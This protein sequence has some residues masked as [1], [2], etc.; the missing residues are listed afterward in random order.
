M[1]AIALGT[2]VKRV[3]VLCGN[4]AAAITAANVYAERLREHDVRFLEEK[5]LSIGR[6]AA[7][8]RR[9]LRAKGPVSLA[10]SLAYYGLR[11]FRPAEKPERRYRPALVTDNFNADPAIREYIRDFMPD[12]VLVACCGILGPDMLALLPEKTFNIH[13]GISPRYRGFGNI[14]A[15]RD[16]RPD[17][18]GYTV[19]KVDAGIDTGERITV[20]RLTPRDIAGV[21]FT[22][23]DVPVYALAADH[24]ADLLLD[25]AEAAI[26][27]EFRE[28]PSEFHGVPTLSVYLT[29]RKNF[30]ATLLNIPRH[31]LITGASSGIGSALA[32]CCAAPGVRLSLWARDERRLAGV[33]A[34][35]RARGAEVVV[36]SQDIRDH[37]RTRELLKQIDR[38]RPVDL[39]VL[40]AGVSS[41]TLPGGAPEPVEAA[42][43]TMDVN[44]TAAVNMAGTL[45]ALMQPR[46]AGHVA[47]ISS[48]AALH[49]LPD[50]PAY[51][52]SKAALAYYARAVRPLLYPLRVS[53]IYPGYVD[54]PMSARIAGPQP[55]RW[56]VERAAAHIRARLDAGAE[57]IVFPRLL[58]L[59]VLL[60]NALPARLAN[61]FLKWFAFR[62][63]PGKEHDPAPA[64]PENRH[65]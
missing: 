40:G 6:I 61:F 28:M 43:R 53:V 56:T 13:P 60:L 4:D 22:G 48:I 23:I 26:P 7:F 37:E 51:S 1:S 47:C 15:L 63:D 25:R 44:A 17:L 50:S 34:R 57:T 38:E 24:L 11:L 33:A 62:I 2:G 35:C 27:D 3:L 32:V 54:S 14:W 12:A 9:R 55:L 64:P 39:A 65:G 20:A 21:P 29:A 16:N 46:G 36:I 42:C 8:C 19:H 59:G 52:A 31:I 5:H 10:G 45:F 58:A 30:A 49:P 18:L 41:G